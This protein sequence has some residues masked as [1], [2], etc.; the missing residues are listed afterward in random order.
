[1]VNNEPNTIIDGCSICVLLAKLSIIILSRVNIMM[2]M[3]FK[4][5]IVLKY[6]FFLMLFKLLFHVR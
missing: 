5:V 4:L 6:K 2:Q 1:M 3:C